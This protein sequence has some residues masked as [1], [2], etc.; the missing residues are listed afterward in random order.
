MDEEV[1]KLLKMILDKAQE[2]IADED[3]D[4]CPYDRY[5]G[6][7]DDAYYGGQRDGEAVFARELVG[8]FK[9][10]FYVAKIKLEIP[11]S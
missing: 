11:S 3:E 4:F 2:D 5:G 6:N 8:E 7:M 10:L 1:Q 9:V